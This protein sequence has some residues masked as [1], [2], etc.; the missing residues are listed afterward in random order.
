MTDLKENNTW[1]EVKVSRDKMIEHIIYKVMWV[2]KY[3]MCWDCMSKDWRNYPWS[4]KWV[5]WICN[6]CKLEW[7]D[8]WLNWTRE[9]Y[10]WDCMIWDILDYLKRKKFNINNIP[11]WLDFV[12]ETTD[13]NK[14]Y[15]IYLYHRNSTIWLRE[16]LRKP[17]Y[18]QTSECIEYIYKLL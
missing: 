7:E 17:I 11:L 9:S 14:Q 6:F 18:Q 5:S 3:L 2:N 12:K 15:S 10:D 1:Q 8:I 16:Y 13:D 4:T